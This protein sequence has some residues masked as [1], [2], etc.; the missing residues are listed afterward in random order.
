[1]GRKNKQ[2]QK[3]I[4]QTKKPFIVNQN[5]DTLEI[6]YIN[7]SEEN[8]K[9]IY[10]S[11][12]D[13]LAILKKEAQEIETYN[14]NMR[15]VKHDLHCNMGDF[16]IFAKGE[17]RYTYRIENEDIKITF[18]GGKYSNENPVLKVKFS[19]HYLFAVGHRKA[20]EDT[21]YLIHRLIGNEYKRLVS[22]I[23]LATD[24][25]G[26]CYTLLDRAMFQTQ[27]KNYD[28][29]DRLYSRFG[30]VQTISFGGGD[31]M[32]RIYNKTDEIKTNVSKSFVA[33]K[34]I[35]NGYNEDDKLDVWRHEVQFRRSFL[36][37][38]ISNLDDEV[39]VV[40][41][42]LGSFWSLTFKKVMHT[43]L[44]EKEVM[45]VQSG[46][47]KSGSIRQLFY[48]AKNDE[49]RIN[50]FPTL[51]VWD[52]RFASQLLDYKEFKAIKMKSVERQIKSLITV[53]VKAGNGDPSILKEVYT[54]LFYE[55]RK[56]GE[57]LYLNSLDKV[58]NNFVKDKKLIEAFG[59]VTDNDYRQQ[60]NAVLKTAFEK[61]SKV[62]YA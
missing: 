48:R 30:R 43:Q 27:Y 9:K 37:K 40:F 29:T 3:M 34:W 31:F 46:T 23:D 49:K 32:F 21:E 24:V 54:N 10:Q 56:K 33:R 16:F 13:L 59:F 42:N 44:N 2:V 57:N 5:V 12:L 58:S 7:L 6:S 55:M 28:Y 8:H 47:L 25:C 53:S 61:L 26:I 50:F 51:D 17:G 45:R 4:F 22:R 62:E 52:N 38:Y 20:V 36:K 60:A 18:F 41:N 39:D 1:M 14:D 15:F 35:L 19:A 11:H